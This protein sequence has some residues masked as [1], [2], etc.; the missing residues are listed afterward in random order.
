MDKTNRATPVINHLYKCVFIH[1]RKCAG[2][3]VRTVFGMEVTDPDWGFANDGVQSP[4]YETT[5]AGYFRFAVVRNPWDR[6]VSGWKCC[7]GTKDRSLFELLSNLPREGFDYRHVARTQCA[8]LLGPDGK[9]AVD[10]LM[11][12][13]TLQTDFEVVCAR[14]GMPT[15]VLPK[16]N[17]GDRH[18][19]TWYFDREP[20]ARDLFD[21]LFADDIRVFDYRY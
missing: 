1:Q 6:F 10:Y 11:R 12:F 8:T 19:H 21:S 18:P 7:P 3:S 9:P 16:V 17:V 2:T 15:I 13:E 4:E 5:P 14:I 20:R